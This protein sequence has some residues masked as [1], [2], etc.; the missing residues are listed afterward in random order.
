MVSSVYYVLF[1]VCTVTASTIMYKDWENQTAASICWQAPRV[2]PPSPESP[3]PGVR[4]RH[5]VPP[6]RAPQV[7]A[8]LILVF[9]VHVL[10][11]TKDS[12]AG[13]AP[14]MRAILGRR[15]RKP[16]EYRLC[17]GDDDESKELCS[18]LVEDEESRIGSPA[19]PKSIS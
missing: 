4:S 9:G 12:P 1:T 17:V 18:A 14:G 19:S 16:D 8:L 10:S 7:V 2:T 13:C 3:A 5:V 6:P 11:S 15:P